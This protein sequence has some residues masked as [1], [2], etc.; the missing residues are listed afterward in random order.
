M[1]LPGQNPPIGPGGLPQTQ[2]L[3]MP[4]GGPQMP[5]GAPSIGMPP[6]MGP[7]LPSGGPQNVLP[8]GALQGIPVNQQRLPQP[9][10]Q[11]ANVPIPGLPP[12]NIGPQN[13]PNLPQQFQTQSPKQEQSQANNNTGELISFD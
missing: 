7:P 11:P 2:S 13:Q 9:G 8:P 10:Q 12:Q 3:V 5:S 1:P 4:P 6:P